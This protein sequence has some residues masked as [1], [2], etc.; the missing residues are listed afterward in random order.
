LHRSSLT[1]WLHSSPHLRSRS[2]SPSKPNHRNPWASSR[3]D[4]HEIQHA[5]HY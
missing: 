1:S 4:E 3:I 2:A 5:A